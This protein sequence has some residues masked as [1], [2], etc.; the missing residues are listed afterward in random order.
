MH[1]ANAVVAARLR[2]MADLLDD[3]QED[4]F[5]ANAYRRAAS[6]VERLEESVVAILARR[7][8]AGL[9]ALPAIGRGIAAVI[10]ELA[11]TG[12]WIALERLSGALEPSAA[13]RAIPGV[14][15]TLSQ[16]IAD[17]LD[18]ETLEQLEMAAHDGR[19]DAV[20][21][22]GR[23]R[24]AAIRTWL[25]DRLSRRRFSAAR[26][27]KRA[28]IKLL[29][30]VDASYRKQ[31]AA[32]ALRKIA[33]RRFNP[34]RAAWLPVLHENHAPWRCTALYSNTQ[35]AHALGKTRDWVV[36]YCEDAAGA[37]QQCTI[38]TETR[39][40]LKGRRVVRGREGECADFYAR[41]A[42]KP[43]GAG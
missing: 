18:I 15:P 26:P 33:P 42:K 16:R 29:L 41:Q 10:V 37:E 6:V 30:D 13:F 11:E 4:G 35:R 36:L 24:L 39:G 34:D 1:E 14:G 43:R 22:L 17:T 28:P 7:G 19:L 3:Q 12:R 20:A 27:T 9:I 8:R 5:R 31:A 2:E 23:R 25:R 38:V 32:G 40:P 21:G